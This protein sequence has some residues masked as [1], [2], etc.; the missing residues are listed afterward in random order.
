MVGANA[1]YVPALSDL[2]PL[3]ASLIYWLLLF[4]G[5]VAVIIIL[6]SGIRFILSG[7]EAKTVETAKKSMTYAILGLLLV[8][9]SFLIL[10]FIGYVTGVAC[11]ENI[12]KG[13]LSFSACG[14]TAP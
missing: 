2:P 4:S 3:L 1:N 7:G 11:L 5:T 14:T 12:A 9:F 13:N 10:N 8:F 6:I